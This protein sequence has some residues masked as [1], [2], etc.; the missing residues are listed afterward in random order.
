MNLLSL[1]KRGYQAQTRQQIRVLQSQLDQLTARKA[2]PE[3]DLYSELFQWSLGIFS[4]F[5]AG[6]ACTFLGAT[7]SDVSDIVRGR[8]L[9]AALVFFIAA[10]VMSLTMVNYSRDLTSTGMRKKTTKLEAQIAK[11]VSKLLQ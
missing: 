8:L 6:I 3:K 1:S 7:S 4:I 10:V 5:V 9:Y 2:A 11:L